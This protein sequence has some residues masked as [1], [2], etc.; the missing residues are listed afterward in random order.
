[1]VTAGKV[2]LLLGVVERQPFH[3]EGWERREAYLFLGRILRAPEHAW[4][5]QVWDVKQARGK[6]IMPSTSSVRHREKPWSA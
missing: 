6:G 2:V 3:L 1:M 4:A 5:I